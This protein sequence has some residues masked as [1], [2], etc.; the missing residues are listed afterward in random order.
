MQMNKKNKKEG[1]KKKNSKDLPIHI[2]EPIKY[3]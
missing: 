3:V 1:K 2:E